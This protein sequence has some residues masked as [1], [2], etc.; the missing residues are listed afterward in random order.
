MTYTD[1]VLG[2]QGTISGRFSTRLDPKS[3]SLRIFSQVRH[4][5]IRQ[6]EGYEADEPPLIEQY[7]E[8]RE[9]EQISLAKSSLMIL[10]A[11]G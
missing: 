7:P 8:S 9:S 10:A 2:L 5:C 11:F 6:S 4:Q 1:S 3:L